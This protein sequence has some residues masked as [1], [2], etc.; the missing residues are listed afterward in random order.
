MDRFPKA[1]KLRAVVL[2][3]ISESRI[4]MKIDLNTSEQEAANKLL[5]LA[6]KQYPDVANKLKVKSDGNTMVV[7]QPGVDRIYGL[8]E[9]NDGSLIVFD[10]DE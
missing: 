1:T 5:E 9:L 3:S 7:M 2:K 4:E 6:K 8:L 10:K